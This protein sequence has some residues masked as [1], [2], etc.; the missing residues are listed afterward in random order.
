MGLR[1]LALGPR[2]RSPA[3]L[4]LLLEVALPELAWSAADWIASRNLFQQ[5]EVK[6]ADGTLAMITTLH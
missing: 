3:A 1:C 6:V 4:L 2:S 5:T